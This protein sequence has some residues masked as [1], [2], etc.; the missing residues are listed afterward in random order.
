MSVG[1]MPDSRLPKMLLH[2][3]VARQNC[4][5]KPRTVWNDVVLS[6]IHKL[7]LN[8]YIRDAQNKPVWRDLT[9]VAC[10]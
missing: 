1:R 4:R 9:Y 10:T 7:K 6:D 5:G 8:H 3:Q 2:G